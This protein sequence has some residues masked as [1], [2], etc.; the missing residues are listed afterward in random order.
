MLKGVFGLE[1]PRDL[2]AKLRHDFLLLQRSPFDPYLAYNFFVTA[3][4]ML[5][6]LYPGNTNRSQR[7]SLRSSEVLLQITS[8]LASGAKHF[9]ALSNHHKS[10]S[11]STPSAGWFPR[12]YFPKGFF[13]TGYFGQGTLTVHLE[14][15][16]QASLGAAIMAV[17][18]AERVLAYWE[19]PG[20]IV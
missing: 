14:G 6:W 11:G 1:N 19:A 5:D 13:P 2:L 18:L 20:R 10:V 12:N 15:E 9:T 4:H 7:E 8:H 16:A 17:D 3:E